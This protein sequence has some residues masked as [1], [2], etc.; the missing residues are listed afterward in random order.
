MIGEDEAHPYERPPLSKALLKKTVSSEAI[1][2]RPRSW[3]SENAIELIRGCSA[4]SIDLR[5]RRVHIDRGSPIS[6]DKVLI[7]TGAS[8]RKLA[9]AEG[10]RV[11]YL[12]NMADA[13][14][15][16]AYFVAGS[17]IAIVGGGL[18]GAEVAATARESGVDVVLIEPQSVLMQNTAGAQVGQLY[19][20][21]H[22]QN[23]VRLVMGDTPARVRADSVGVEIVTKAGTKIEAELLLICVGILPN[24]EIARSANIDVQ[25]GIV[26][27]QFFK[28][29]HPAVY[30]AGDVARAFY[31]N[32]SLSMRTESHDSAIRQG[33]GA[34][35]N[36]LGRAEPNSDVPWG[37]SDQYGQNLQFAGC[38][39]IAD[40]SIVRGNIE[41]GGFSV[42][43]TRRGRLCAALSFNRGRE[44]IIARRMIAA[45]AVVNEALV[46]DDGNNLQ[47][48]FSVDA[49]PAT[50]KCEAEEGV[51]SQH[52]AG[53]A[54]N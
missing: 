26:V 18:I 3:Y 6:F 21:M 15:I 54:P 22:Q 51:T 10:Q 8:P 46:A 27:D 13:L 42:L 19:S 49:K 43:Y 29:S 32:F 39:S 36:M 50:P 47:K 25:N 23:G 14:R 9:G 34:A 41:S 28:A 37:W 38:R 53:D 52:C 5:E 7:A 33:A 12:R 31:P 35:A 2:V 44:M 20:R 16:S 4:T 40:H 45:S 30:A 11:F 48:G 1:E 24:D 17:R